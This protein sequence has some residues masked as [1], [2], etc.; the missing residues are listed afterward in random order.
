MRAVGFAVL[1]THLKIGDGTKMALPL[2]KR[3]GF[4]KKLLSV[5]NYRFRCKFS[6]VFLSAEL[7]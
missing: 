5:T 3:G 1:P 2:I 7:Y 4:G 6:I